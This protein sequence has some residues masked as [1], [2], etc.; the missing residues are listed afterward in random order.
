MHE[1]NYQKSHN[2]NKGI[3]F[4]DRLNSGFHSHVEKQSIIRKI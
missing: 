3:E 1:D 2:R 4:F